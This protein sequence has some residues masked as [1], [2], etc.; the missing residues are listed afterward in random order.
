M[1][2]AIFLS[3]FLALAHAGCEPGPSTIQDSAVDTA[4]DEEPEVAAED[5][6][7]P[8]DAL[9]EPDAGP[10]DVPGEV[11]GLEG[12][13][14][15][16]AYPPEPW[17]THLPDS[18]MTPVTEPLANVTLEG[19]LDVDGDGTIADEAWRSF[20][21]EDL[22]H[23]CFKHLLLMIASPDCPHCEEELVQLR[24][25]H[26]AHRDT[27]LMVLV[28]VGDAPDPTRAFI[29]SYVEHHGLF[30][31]VGVDVAGQLGAIF[32]TGA[33]GRT[34]KNILV[35]LE[36]MQVGQCCQD[37]DAGTPGRITC[38]LEGYSGLMLDCIEREHEAWVDG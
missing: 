13:R 38:W 21:L 16:L 33:T 36:T 35:D 6:V 26:A 12:C 20:T 34:P 15:D 19:Y 8:T 18:Q 31:P 9:A 29:D 30:M 32:P 17:I 37:G 27:G 2:R 24:S 3:L 7:D 28:L 4:L 23:S 5:T 1:T 22:Y 11:P 25:L 10:P 14:E